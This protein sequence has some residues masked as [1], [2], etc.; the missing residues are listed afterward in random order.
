M[1]KRYIHRESGKVL[2]AYE[3]FGDVWIV[4]SRRPS[5]SLQRFKSPALPPCRDRE[6]CQANLDAFAAARRLPEAGPEPTADQAA[7][8]VRSVSVPCPHGGLGSDAE[9]GCRAG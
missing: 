6:T 8:L 5:G 2:G 4:A 9:C 1:P 7:E 3:S